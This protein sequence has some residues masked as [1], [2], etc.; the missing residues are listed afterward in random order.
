L[1]FAGIALVIA[2][3]LYTLNRERGG[4]TRAAA[5]AQR[6]PAQ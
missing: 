6:S 3:G 4:L 5:P 2:A 1:A